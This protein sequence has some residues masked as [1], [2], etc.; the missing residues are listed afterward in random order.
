VA[1]SVLKGLKNTRAL[2]GFDSDDKWICSLV[3]YKLVLSLSKE[4]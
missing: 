4:L 1:G 3:S 2:P